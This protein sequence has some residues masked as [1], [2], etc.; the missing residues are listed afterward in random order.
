MALATLSIDLVAQLANLQSGMDKA[1]RLAERQAA[2]IESRY[3]RIAEVG[4]AVGATLAGAISVAGLAAFFKTTVDGL[5]ALNDVKDATGATIE[6][7]SALEDLAARTGTRFENVSIALQKFNKLLIDARPGSEIAN[8]LTAIGLSAEDLKKQD[9]AEGLRQ[10][11]VALNSYEEGGAKARLEQRLFGES[12]AVLGA[13][14]KNLAEQGQLNA[15]VTAKQA[16]EAERFNRELLAFQKNASDA[17]RAIANELLPAINS[18]FGAAKQEGGIAKL[19]GLDGLAGKVDQV[20]SAYQ[21]LGLARERITPL[22]ILEKDPTNRGALAE[23]ARIDAKGK[24]LAATFQEARDKMLGIGSSQAGAGRGFINPPLIKPAAPD[25]PGATKPGALSAAK[26]ERLF[27]GPLLDPVRV[28]ALRAIEQT[29][30]VRIEKL[31]ETLTDLLSLSNSEGSPAVAVAIQEVIDKIAALDPASKALADRAARI[32][33]ALNATP[34]AKK[35]DARARVDELQ[36]ELGKTKDPARLRQI[37]EAIDAIYLG[38]GA[39]PSVAEPVFAELDEYTKNFAANVQ[40]T[41]GDTIFNALT[42]SF[43][44]IGKAWLNMLL[45]MGSDAL[46]ADL[47]R[48]LFPGSKGAGDSSLGGLF[49][50]ITGGIGGLFGGLFGGGRATGGGVRAG[51]VYGVVEQ[52][53]ELLQVGN[54]TMLL[55]GKQ[56]GQVVPASAGSGQSSQAPIY[57]TVNNVFNTGVQ[58]NEMAAFGAAIQ[59]KVLT[60]VAESQRR[61]YSGVPA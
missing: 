37:E 15:T 4:R 28:E 2:V 60:A 40:A 61:R 54:R 45:R 53:P 1:G 27:V 16:E 18:L 23:L 41:F 22:S 25:I 51:G 42:G 17:A 10:V 30:T 33:A 50:A 35:Q 34:A 49:N 5:D 14:L 11:A 21:L 58:R 24:Q 29:D 20:V 13:F 38:I 7:I 59:S 31:R 39:I 43:D 56:G 8:T 9:P 36:A 19:L 3:A 6:N 26:P 52:G 48:A 32:D 44:N 46:A 12:T 47:T 57:V 55:M